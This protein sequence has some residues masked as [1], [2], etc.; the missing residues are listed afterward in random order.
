MKN[1]IKGYKKRKRLGTADIKDSEQEQ[2]SCI[3]ILNFIKK[4]LLDQ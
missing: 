4:Y 3:H 1:L 2:H